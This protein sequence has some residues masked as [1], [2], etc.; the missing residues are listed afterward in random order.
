MSDAL[1]ETRLEFDGA[2]PFLGLVLGLVS[3]SARWRAILDAAAP[4]PA[5]DDPPTAVDHPGVD[6]LLGLI[7]LTRRLDAH[8]AAVPS[9]D[10]PPPA[11]GGEA[12]SRYDVLR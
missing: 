7:A 11:R 4:A 8:L 2:N 6:A 12:R 9:R 1:H 5:E 3:A 10:D